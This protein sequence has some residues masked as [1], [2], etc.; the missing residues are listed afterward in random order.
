MKRE[1]LRGKTAEGFPSI[2]QRAC[3][4]TRDLALIVPE[5]VPVVDG[6]EG[7]S[8]APWHLLAAP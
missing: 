4:G 3:Y 1:D 7:V 5:I 2:R 6:I 8:S